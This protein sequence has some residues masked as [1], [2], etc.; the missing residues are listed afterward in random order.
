MDM[1]AFRRWVKSLSHARS[2]GGTRRRRAA[3]PLNL[4]ALETRTVPSGIP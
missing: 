4:E 3:R 2:A 1:A